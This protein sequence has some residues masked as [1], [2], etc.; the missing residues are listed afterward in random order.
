MSGGDFGAEAQSSGM[1][2]S[3]GSRS[4]GPTGDF[5]KGACPTPQSAVPSISKL[6]RHLLGLLLAFTTVGSVHRAALSDWELPERRKYLEL[7][8]LFMPSRSISRLRQ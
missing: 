2:S 6:A 7:V 3:L 4:V 8:T 1:L 5:H